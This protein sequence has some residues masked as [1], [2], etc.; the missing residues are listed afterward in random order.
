MR[1]PRLLLRVRRRARCPLR[2]ARAPAAAAR[3]PRRRSTGTCGSV[4][5]ETGAQRPEPH[6][7]RCPQIRRAGRSRTTAS[8]PARVAPRKRSVRCQLATGTR[9]PRQPLRQRAPQPCVD[10][11][12]RLVTQRHADDRIA[13]RNHY[14]MSSIAPIARSSR[15][16]ITAFPTFPPGDRAAAG[17]ACEWAPWLPPRSARMAHDPHPPVRDQASHAQA[18]QVAA[19]RTPPRA[20]PTDHAAVAGCPLSPVAAVCNHSVTIAGCTATKP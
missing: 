15:R 2:C 4:A 20:P 13:R 7:D 5:A 3:P 12:P 14:P 17:E 9:A 19:Q 10:F 16:N 11:P 1:L 18:A 6:V 8:G